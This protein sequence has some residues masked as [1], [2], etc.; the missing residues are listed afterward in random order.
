[1]TI[2]VH[3]KKYPAKV[4]LFGEYTVLFGG[5]ALAIPYPRYS[6]IWKKVGYPT[7][8]QF[9][10][11]VTHL[12]RVNEQLV[13]PL[14]LKAFRTL[15]DQQYL[16]VS[17]IPI[18]VGLGSSA[19]LT[20]SLY[21]MFANPAGLTLE[22]R[23][24]DLALIESFYHGKSSGFDALVS[25]QQKSLIQTATGIIQMENPPTAAGY[26]YLLYTGSPRNT[27]P[28]VQWFQKACEDKRFRGSMEWLA[29]VSK[30]AIMQYIRGKDTFDTVQQISRLQL[31]LLDHLIIPELRDLWEKA[32]SEDHYSL[33]I[34][35]AGGGGCYLVFSRRQISGDRLDH[36][37]IEEITWQ[38][39]HQ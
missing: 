37:L 7:F 36:Y 10:D 21:D 22:A 19:A 2:P 31:K 18:G 8:R 28:L 9:A 11:L 3:L 20:A 4:L 33:K 25:L 15:L 39:A 38:P 14:D 16:F 24:N 5:Q 35:G 32:L 27:Q 23:K 29:E 13:S 26:S 12:E 30:K 6:G 1:L 17:D 34:C